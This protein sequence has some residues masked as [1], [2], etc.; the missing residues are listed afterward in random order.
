MKNM[1]GLLTFIAFLLGLLLLTALLSWK[2][3]KKGRGR[4]QVYQTDETWI[5]PAPFQPPV[6][7]EAFV[8]PAPA[9]TYQSMMVGVWLPLA[10]ALFTGLL[11]GILAFVISLLAG[12]GALVSLRWMGGVGIIVLCLVWLSRFIHWTKVVQVMELM[13]RHDF[14]QDGYEGPPPAQVVE[15]LL[16]HHNEYGDR[17]VTDR[18]KYPATF[19]QMEALAIAVLR[20]G[21]PFSEDALAGSRRPFSQNELSRLRVQFEKD[22]LISPRGKG[23][24]TG[25]EFTQEGREVLHEFLPDNLKDVTDPAPLPHQAGR[26]TTVSSTASTQAREQ[27]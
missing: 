3:G 20:Q 22:G 25:W 17:T 26:V 8:Q 21:K 15:V 1:D 13:F 24:N 4:K 16:H 18:R 5:A 19:R 2:P 14:N 12:A 7:Q 6:R 27:A 23:T 11:L 10:Q 9:P